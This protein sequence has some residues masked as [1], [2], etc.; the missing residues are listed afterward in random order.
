MA[1]GDRSRNVQMQ[2]PTCAATDFDYDDTSEFVICASCG[3]EISKD[4]LIESNSENIHLNMEEMKKEITQD[5]RK[6]LSKIFKKWK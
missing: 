3:L 5:V 4:E 1:I 2:C 6:E